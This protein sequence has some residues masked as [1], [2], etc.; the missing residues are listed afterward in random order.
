MR[1][2]RT[3]AALLLAASAVA[4]AA[5]TALADSDV[6]SFGFGAA[7]DTVAPGGSVTLRATGCPERTTVSAPALFHDVTLGGGGDRGQAVTVRI[8]G[9]A[10]PGTQYDISFTC[11]F[12]KGTTPLMIGAATTAAPA[13]PGRAVRTGLGGAVSGLNSVE[14][15][16]GVALIGAAG[17]YLVRRR[18]HRY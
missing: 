1:A 8:A 5:P 9:A 2:G 4:L 3:T 12:E 16:A 17:A 10:K 13:A 7:P 14:I 15:V 11:G 6:I 18:A